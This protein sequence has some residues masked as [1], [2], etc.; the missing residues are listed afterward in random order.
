MSGETLNPTDIVSRIG[1]FIRENYP[2]KEEN[3]ALVIEEAS[4]CNVREDL[5]AGYLMRRAM[6]SAESEGLTRIS[7]ED[8]PTYH[9]PTLIAAVKLLEKDLPEDEKKMTLPKE[10]QILSIAEFTNARNLGITAHLGIASHVAGKGI[11]LANFYE[12]LKRAPE[13]DK[14]FH[15]VKKFNK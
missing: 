4:A 15:P 14:A 1:T 5:R 9:V 11:V 10:V 7:E 12:E 8:Y 2:F 13:F 3:V 6:V